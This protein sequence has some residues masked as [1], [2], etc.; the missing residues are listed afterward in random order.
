MMFKLALGAEKNWRKLRGH[1]LIEKVVRRVK[2]K[3]GE[4]IKEEAA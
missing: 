2:F 1:K 3:D 4:E